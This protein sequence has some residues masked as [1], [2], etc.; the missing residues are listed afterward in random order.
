MIIDKKE[1]PNIGEKAYLIEI[2]GKKYIY[3]YSYIQH[4]STIYSIENNPKNPWG[5][6]INFPSGKQYIDEILSDFYS[7][8]D[9]SNKIHK[10]MLL[11]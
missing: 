7:K 6:H 5:Y 11:L 9:L 8:E 2:C 1:Y 4:K 10:L 3:L